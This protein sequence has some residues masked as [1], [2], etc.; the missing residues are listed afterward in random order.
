MKDYRFF[1]HNS[2]YKPEDQKEPTFSFGE[3]K[4]R[5]LG[6]IT[7]NG[8][9]ATDMDGTMFTNDL[10]IL[11]F[12]EML[13]KSHEWYFDPD[14]FASLL[15]PETYGVIINLAL[16]GELPNIET[17]KAKTF[18]N[19]KDDSID[20]YKAIYKEQDDY[21]LTLEHPLMNEFAR[22]MLELDRIGME[23]EHIFVKG[24]NGQLFSR[25]RFFLNHNSRRISR[26]TTAAMKSHENGGRIAHLAVHPKSTKVANQ[27]IGSDD[28]EALDYDRQIVVVE[29]IRDVINTLM[30]I[31]IPVRVVTTNL[32]DIAQGA[33]LMSSYKN[34]L[35]QDCDGKSPILASKLKR[36]AYGKMDSHMNKLPILGGIKA[37]V[38]RRLESVLGKK[39]QLAMGDS[40][41]NDG[42]MM[43]LSLNNGGVA[44]IVPKMGEDFEK[45]R[46]NHKEWIDKARRNVGDANIGDRIY[47]LDS[48][49]LAVKEK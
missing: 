43:E 2:V 7:D 36:N 44:I 48:D 39:V 27:R 33:L 35:D 40:P 41:S 38:L 28:L 5:Y 21:D 46:N 9:A 4:D 25:M 14:E 45:T 30:Q 1:S 42:D 12:L 13:S 10:G 22:K 19:L 31:E 20:L 6:D 32:H 47:Y 34:I 49:E 37:K 3:I 17:E 18:M 29:G 26:L 16:A 23:M 24:M 8:L 15:V 11:V